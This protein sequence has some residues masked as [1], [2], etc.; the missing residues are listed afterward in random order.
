[1][2]PP[3]GISVS[4]GRIGVA[5]AARVEIGC[6]TSPPRPRTGSERTGRN[7][8]GEVDTLSRYIY[9]HGTPE[10]ALIGMPVSHGCIRM[11]N[12]DLLQLFD[13]V[14]QGTPVEIID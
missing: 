9:I 11:R 1:M 13:W 7:R 2:K 3:I 5:A 6:S 8:G 12:A 10:T 4:P 14:E